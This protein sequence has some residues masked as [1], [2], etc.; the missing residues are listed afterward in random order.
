MARKKY[1]ANADNTITNAFRSNLSTRGVDANMG[2]SDV[3]E[4]FSI[5]GQASSGSTELSRILINFPVSEIIADRTAGVTPEA[6]KTKFYLNLYNAVTNQTVPRHM[7]LSVYA[8]SRSWQEGTGL[9]MAEYK[10]IV[11]PGDI[12]STWISASS[13]EAWTR[14]GGDYHQSPV[15]NSYFDTG[16]ENLS[17]DITSLVEEWIA[18][19]KNNYG[20]GIHLSA[21]QEAY[22]SRYYPRESVNFDKQAFLSGSAQSMQLTGPSTISMWVK[23]D[24]IG[25]TQYMMFWQQTGFPS[26]GRVLYMNATGQL[27]YARKY[28]TQASY[29][30]V[31]TLSSGVWSHIV[32]TD[33]GDRTFPVLYIDGAAST[34]AETSPGVGSVPATNFDMLAI[35]GSRTGDT[36]NWD[37]L[38]DDV[39]YFDKVLSSGEVSEI[40]NSDCPV[41][42]KQTSVYPSLINWWV[43]GDD[44]RDKIKLGTP[45]TQISIH[46]RAGALNM[47]AT[48]TGGMSI[49]DGKC[50]GQNGTVPVGK[51]QIINNKGSKTSYYTKKFFGRGSE[52][53]FN[54]PTIEARWDSSKKDDRGQIY[55]ES[56]LL[57]AADNTNTIYLYNVHN[58]RLKDIPFIGTGADAL[59]VK[60]FN[61]AAG[62]NEITG[63]TPSTITA[64]RVSRGI[65]TASFSLISSASIGYD[66]WYNPPLSEV[67]HTGNFYLRDRKASGYNPYP[68][69]VTSVTNLRDTY[70]SHETARFRFYVRQK[71]WSPTIYTVATTET[72][73]LI[74]ES[75]SYQIHRLIDDKV[76]IPFD[77]GSDKSTEMSYDVSGNYFDLRMDLFEPGYSYGLKVSYYDDSVLSYVEQPNIWKFR[78][79][80]LESQ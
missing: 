33:A 42:I 59:T 24:T 79:E 73:S 64:G 62:G 78:V 20:I 80:K 52:F 13:T 51:Y 10:D 58:G 19:T 50:S 34:L 68:N 6:G 77:T 56:N 54:R 4:T 25:I 76:V 27:V 47:Y 7:Y 17:L 65:Y 37:G 74:I 16:V 36:N 49:V 2:A 46:D 71:D 67:Y 31:A 69:Y 29:V 38:I 14:M 11:K 5:Y 44:P 48:G 30:S 57:S 41:D 43:H 61:A 66:R 39:A 53:F 9:D 28:D 26:F 70:Y 40:Y 1:F 45:P 32:L 72:D 15:Y 63:T 22:Y 18:G 35:G 12:G 23:P 55:T 60:I 8:V 75:S 21:S 3:L